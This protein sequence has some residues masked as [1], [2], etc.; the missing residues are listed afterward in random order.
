[1]KQSLFP[2]R[3][4]RLI[5]GRRGASR[6]CCPGC[7]SKGSARAILTKRLALVGP[8]CPGLSASTVTRL[9]EGWQAEYQEWSKRSLKDKHYVYLWVD[10]VHFNIRLEE[11]RQCILVLMGAA[12]DGKKE[13]IAIVDRIEQYDVSVLAR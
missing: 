3:F 11:D 9:L 6:S 7:T 10:G 1:M 2:P 5:C 13:L 8:D 4:C 12:A